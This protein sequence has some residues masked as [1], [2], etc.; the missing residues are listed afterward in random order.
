MS[1]KPKPIRRILALQSILISMVPFFL[2][3]AVGALFLVP[4]FK[5]GARNEQVRLSATIA[6][7]VENYL[8]TSITLLKSSAAALSKEGWDAKKESH[9]L[10]VN[11][12]QAKALEGIAVVGP[13]GKLTDIISKIPNPKRHKKALGKNI[14]HTPFYKKVRREQRLIWSPIYLPPGNGNHAISIGIPCGERTLVGQINMD[15]FCRFLKGITTGENQSILVLDRDGTILIEASG[16]PSSRSSRLKH[17]PL[18]RRAL[19]LNQDSVC[20]EFKF[21]GKSMVGSI[22]K[23]RFPNWNI[24]VLTPTRMVYRPLETTFVILV[25]CLIP[26]VLGAIC[27]SILFANRMSDRFEILAGQLRRLAGGQSTTQWPRFAI[28]EFREFSK[29]LRQ[30][31]EAITQREAYNRIL[32]ADSPAAMLV[33]DARTQECRDCNRAA[34][35]L[36]NLKRPEDMAGKRL[37]DFSPP[38]QK[39]PGCSPGTLQTYFD[40]CMET[41]QVSFEWVFQQKNQGIWYGDLTLSRFTH[42]HREQIQIILHD[43]SPAKKMEEER[44]TLEHQLLQAQKME[45]IGTLSGGIAHDFNNLLFPI[46]GYAEL[47]QME[48]PKG[49]FQREYLDKIV[50]AV[51]RARDLVRRILTFSRREGNQLEEIQLHQV[52]KEA[53]KLVESTL[54]ATITI[55]HEIHESTGHIMG[56]ATQLH[57]VIMN[58]CTNALHA[59]EDKEDQRELSLN[60]TRL[61]LPFQN[62]EGQGEFACLEIS[63]TGKGMP[64]KVMEQIFHP[65]FTTKDRGKGTGLGL[66]VVHGI[67]K[68]HGGHIAVESKEGVGSTF[69]IFFPLSKN[70]PRPLPDP[71]PPTKIQEGKGHILVVDDEEMIVNMLKTMLERMG[72]KVSTEVRSV[73]ALERFRADPLE[74][75]LVITDMTMPGMTGYQ[76]TANIRTVRPDIPVI[77]CTGYSET[78]TRERAS[79]LGIKGFLPKPI[80]RSELTEMI[81]Q[82]MGE[83]S[84]TAPELIS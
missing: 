49:S 45:S 65:Y 41:G 29:D 51:Q 78:M 25:I 7:K 60:L 57:Q 53:L 61:S 58:L 37:Q 35:A 18:I 50:D 63:D 9:F 72:F 52:V 11:L 34:L 47:L 27:L 33:L 36:F 3:C 22:Q 40:T 73:R 10:S 82:V 32:F 76:L 70:R 79:E 20:G 2:M 64:P 48:S 62:T 59:M 28:T 24:L 54:P 81:Q 46:S 12:S 26:T 15:R 56:N 68:S 80:L 21:D 30:M 17:V 23:T 69:K 14:S 77:L 67:V 5:D 75:D 6:A 38:A 16:V 42:D 44:K 66:S 84:P 83:P 71:I 43:I 13:Q 39:R 19:V 8:N 31:A 4:Q 74:Y 1:T 55:R